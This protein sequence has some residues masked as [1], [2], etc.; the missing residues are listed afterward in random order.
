MTPWH[1]GEVVDSRWKI[2]KIFPNSGMGV[3]ALVERLIDGQWLVAK[4]FQRLKSQAQQL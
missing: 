4:T 3:V 2:L 1:K